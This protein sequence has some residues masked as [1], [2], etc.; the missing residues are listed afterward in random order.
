MRRRVLI[1]THE[2]PPY[3]GGVATYAHAMADA[4]ARAGHQVT[5]VAPDYGC[6]TDRQDATARF[7]VRRYRAGVYSWRKL[8]QLLWRTLRF[9]RG[10]YDV[11]HAVD[12]PDILALAFW[13]RL[14][15]IPFTATVYGTELLQGPS[16]QAR[17]LGVQNLYDA[18]DRILAISDFTKKVLLD[19]HVIADAGKVVVTHLG[20]DDTWFEDAPAEAVERARARYGIRPEHR[21]VLS[22]SR[23]DPRKGHRLLLRSLRRLPV[24]VSAH[25][26]CIIVGEGGDADYAR[27]LGR[28]AQASPARVVLT[29][30]VS[31]EE[32]RALYGGA[33]VFC[34]PG[35]PHPERVEGFGLVFLEAAAQRLPVLATRIGAV[36]EVVRDRQTGVLVAPDDEVSL[37]EGLVSLLRD[38]PRRRVLGANAREWARSFTWRRCM[39]MSYEGCPS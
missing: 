32:L 9:A 30:R 17:L 1:L 4:A 31:K 8:P 13:K 28:L 25:L 2:F 12:W 23:L 35:E 26:T 38:A 5:V 36:P 24:D 37:A 20:V 21:V 11:V 3:A 16:S 39:A 33:D 29:G 7:E 15:R 27:E 34:L 19:H 10:G 18:P 14:F 22:V 6:C